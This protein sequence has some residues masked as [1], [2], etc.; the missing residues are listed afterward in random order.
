MV[1][2]DRPKNSDELVAPHTKRQRT[3]FSFDV[4]VCRL[5]CAAENT[6]ILMSSIR[7]E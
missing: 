3:L 7:V 6:R 4:V 1:A 2:N 5:G